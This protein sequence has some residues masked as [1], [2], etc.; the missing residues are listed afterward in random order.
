VMTEIVRSALKR[1]FRKRTA[2]RPI[3]V[4]VILEV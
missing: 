4:P 1:F 3:I 2:T